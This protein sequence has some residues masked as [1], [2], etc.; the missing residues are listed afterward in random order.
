M[1]ALRRES[2][3]LD[4]TSHKRDSTGGLLIVWDYKHDAAP[5]AVAGHADKSFTADSRDARWAQSLPERRTLHQRN[6]AS[7]RRCRWLV[8]PPGRG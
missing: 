5:E 1:Q 4:M 7:R 6:Q 2:D 3:A 8:L